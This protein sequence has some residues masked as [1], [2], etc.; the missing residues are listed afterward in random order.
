MKIGDFGWAAYSPDNQ[1]AEKCGTPLYYSPEVI[2]GQ[3]YTRTADNWGVG[4]ICFELIV[5]NIPWSIWTEQEISRIVL[6]L[7]FRLKRI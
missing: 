4:L 6:L 2:R 7:L 3:K 5:G 1:Y